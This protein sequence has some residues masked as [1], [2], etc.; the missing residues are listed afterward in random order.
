MNETDSFAS[1]VTKEESKINYCFNCNKK[2][3]IHLPTCKVSLKQCIRQAV[4]EFRLRWN[5]YKSNNRKY[6]RLESC[7][8]EHLFEHF[9]E[10]GHCGFSDNFSITFIDKTDPSEPLE[11]AN[12]WKS[13]LKKMAPLIL[14]IEDNA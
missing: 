6:Q 2:C 13:V 8:Q 4:D 7:M 1:S 3:S 9:N 11:T 12:Y 5:N 14:N 10:E